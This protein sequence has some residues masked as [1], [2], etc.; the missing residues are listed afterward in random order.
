MLFK[1]I[2]I[3]SILLCA[4]LCCPEENDYDCAVV[5]CPSSVT[6][7]IEVLANNENVFENE[8]YTLE[9]ITI[10]GDNSSDLQL[11]LFEN[12]DSITLLLLEN[13]NWQLGSNTYTLNFPDS[14]L[15]VL[16][17]DIFSSGDVGCC[18]DTPLLDGLQINGQSQSISANFY[19][20]S[21]D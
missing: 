7:A 14:A 4:S 17:I 18:G 1:K 2:L 16:Q 12:E 10:E 8:T 3:G 20:I 5:S 11:S 21:L 9:D 13:S 19:T 15:I 6:V